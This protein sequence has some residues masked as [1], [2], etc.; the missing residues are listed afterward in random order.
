M[1]GLLF[2]DAAPSWGARP[3]GMQWVR[4]GRNSAA[5]RPLRSDV[6]AGCSCELERRTGGWLLQVHSFRMWV[7][8]GVLM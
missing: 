7:S 8:G 6:E 3:P 4:R 2:T 5:R 1:W